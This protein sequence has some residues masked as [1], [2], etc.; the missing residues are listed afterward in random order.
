MDLTKEYPRS[1]RARLLDIPGLPRMID[2]ARATLDG[3]LGEYK[4][5]E[6][7]GNDRSVLEFLGLTAD[8]FLEGVRQSHDDEA[9]AEWLRA[10]ARKIK[11]AE[12][13]AFAAIFVSDGD[14]D[15]D[16]RRFAER[17]AK[18]PEHI[19]RRVTGWVDLLDFDEGRI[20]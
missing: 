13:E 4:Y 7:S 6:K 9:M 14:D 15:E 20:A 8:Q 17:K 10:H 16:R 11:P 2:K 18:L 19:Q 1:P 5:G 3:T 12:I